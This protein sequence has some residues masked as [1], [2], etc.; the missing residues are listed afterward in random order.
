MG[1][2]RER[3][4]VISIAFGMLLAQILVY[5]VLLSNIERVWL[6]WRKNP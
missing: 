2:S 5:I 4:A 6:C 1:D 3:L